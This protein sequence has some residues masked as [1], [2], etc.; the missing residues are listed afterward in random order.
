MR[1]PAET[2][3]QLFN[4]LQAQ[5][6]GNDELQAV[7]RAYALMIELGNCE[8]RS[9]G[10]SLIEHCVGVASILAD[11]GVRPPLVTAGLAHAAYLHGDF[12]SWGR[13]IDPKKRHRVRQAIGSESEEC[14]HRYSHLAWYQVGIGSLRG[15]LSELDAIERDTVL[16]RLADQLDIYGRLDARYAANV[17]KR[18]QEVERR[19]EIVVEFARE[20]GFPRMAAEFQHAFAIFRDT[21][22]P[23]ELTQP[24]W[25]DIVIVPSSYATRPTIRMYRSVRTKLYRLVG[26]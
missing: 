3:V 12:G 5:G 11:L 1:D 25:A 6:Y 17:D 18:H 8:Y 23:A 15:R 10:R 2:I 7:H 26:R 14:V 24:R 22:P 20:L 4:Q 13:R 19:G 16:M 21:N 9:S